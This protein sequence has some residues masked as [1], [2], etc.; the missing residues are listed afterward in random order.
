MKV[1]NNVDTKAV[2]AADVEYV[3][4]LGTMDDVHIVAA[5][6]SSEDEVHKL[7]DGEFKTVL[8]AHGIPD[9]YWT[10]EGL[11]ANGD[12]WSRQSEN[13]KLLERIAAKLTA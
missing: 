9:K 1:L 8:A 6:S 10:R 12:V 13:G 4:Y 3:H 5:V 2:F 7:R 11:Q